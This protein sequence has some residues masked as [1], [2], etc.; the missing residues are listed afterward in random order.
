MSK[1]IFADHARKYWENNLSII[2]CDGK[3]T[4]IT[5]W[6]RYSERLTTEHEIDAWERAY[7]DKNLTLVLGPASGIIAI[8]V[9]IND[10]LISKIVP[11][12]TVERFGSKGCVRF[13][14]YNK[15]AKEFKSQK[16]YYGKKHTVLELFIDSGNVLLPPSIHPDTGKPYIWTTSDTLIDPNFRDTLPELTDFNFFY[17]VK[18]IV[19]AWPEPEDKHS[20]RSDGV[21]YGRNLH[22]SSM[23]SAALF[24]HT[25]REQVIEEI[26]QYDLANHKP[27]LF[28]DASENKS[29]SNA[30]E[31]RAHAG[32]FVDNHIKSLTRKKMLIEPSVIITQEPVK[33]TIEE[34]LPEKLNYKELPEFPG[35][36]KF[37]E[38]VFN[39]CTYSHHPILGK[40]AALSLLSILCV[41]RFKMDNQY[42]N[43][44]TMVL[45]NSSFGKTEYAKLIKF[46]LY[47]DYFKPRNLIGSGRYASD[48]AFCENLPKQRFRLDIHDEFSAFLRN[49]TASDGR[50]RAIAA[51]HTELW[52]HCGYQFHGIKAATRKETFEC[53]S[54]VIN[55]FTACQLD[56]F[57]ESCSI[58]LVELGYIARFLPFVSETEGTL[59]KPEKGRD[60]RLIDLARILSETFPVQSTV[61][62]TQIVPLSYEEQIRRSINLYV[63]MP[64]L[65]DYRTHFH[66]LFTE[67]ETGYY[68][69]LCGKAYEHFLRL[70]IPIT[71]SNENRQIS[72]TD[73]DL[74]FNIVDTLVWNAKIAV[75]RVGVDFRDKQLMQI[76]SWF[77]KNKTFTRR[78]FTRAFQKIDKPKR[79]QILND[80]IET[81]DLTPVENN[82]IYNG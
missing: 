37:I 28:W 5:K 79:D 10:S 69:N 36:L 21:S 55:T 25:P 71:I 72:P 23:A 20:V 34:K 39:S 15:E 40:A 27:P 70:L 58:D 42:P 74:A 12:S 66:K 61:M 17:K 53:Y 2:P 18:D 51:I 50:A 67:A 13:F 22:L 35:L 1:K 64:I 43:I 48:V 4:H 38:D 26:F 59:A 8:D 65:D 46:I 76:R 78:H 6:Q 24:K 7:P 62:L 82:L 56:T 32:K 75:P 54:P 9:D 60:D 45:G 29:A 47:T 52:S 30:N 80:F 49:S 33:I 3:A 68:K 14:K 41:G 44:W 31:A 73:V 77:S 57:K 16:I 63:D 81:G 19:D 11:A